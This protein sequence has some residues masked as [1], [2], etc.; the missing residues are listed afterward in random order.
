MTKRFEIQNK[1]LTEITQNHRKKLK[2]NPFILQ[3]KL[4]ESMGVASNHT[5]FSKH[6]L[7]A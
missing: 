4:R 5:S 2:D 1:T 7:K 6:L 3:L